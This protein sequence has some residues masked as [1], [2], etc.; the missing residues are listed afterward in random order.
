M[1]TF[2]LLLVSV[3][4]GASSQAE[5]INPPQVDYML[6]CQGCHLADGRG[7]PERGVPAMKDTIARFVAVPGGREY[8][9]RVP[10]AS[11]S[12]L[13]DAELAAVLN[14]M[15]VS[16]GPAEQAAGFT[17]YTGEEVAAVRRPPFARV[18]A[19]RKSLVEQFGAERP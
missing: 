4:L 2:I 9:V 18:D 15:I 6:Q 7:A 1:R 14:W 16:F 10:G 11:G 17:P 8:L 3:L 13:S 12:P 5:E 19:L